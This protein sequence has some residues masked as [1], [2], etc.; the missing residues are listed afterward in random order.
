[1]CRWLS[2]SDSSPRTA[3]MRKCEDC[4]IILDPEVHFCPNCGREIDE[5]RSAREHETRS[6]IGV[7]LTSANLHRARREWEQAIADVTEALQLDSSNLDAASLLGAVYEDRGS[8]DDALI[9]SRIALDL[10]PSSVGD[11]V[12]ME[13]VSQR[14]VAER[15]GNR[16]K[17]ALDWRSWTLVGAAGLI[18]VLLMAVIALSIGGRGRGTSQA[19]GGSP[20]AGR[21]EAPPIT[22]PG[23]E[24]RST[25]P[26]AAP[27][28]PLPISGGASSSSSKVRTAAEVAIGRAVSGSRTLQSSG[29]KVDD[30][31]ADPR[32]GLATVTF[33]L[34][35]GVPMGR[36]LILRNAAEAA[37]AAFAAN[38]EVKFVTARCLMGSGSSAQ[39]V[40]VGDAGRAAAETLGDAP[41]LEQ[42]RSVF[43]NPWWNP[44]VSD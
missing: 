44:Q 37:R 19:K 20:G 9:W 24:P 38:S 27:S 39:I 23:S 30:V 2:G 1:V 22:A 14:M 21:A 36:D 7:L 18:V 16:P 41:T 33:S 29:A 31:I 26:R 13:R 42:L 3:Q 15:E 12:R 17:S 43:T 8:L 6:R 10:D 32:H 40:F 35:A 34:P 4:K 5:Q 25:A 11:R 28:G